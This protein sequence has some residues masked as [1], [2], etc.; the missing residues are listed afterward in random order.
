MKIGAII[1]CRYNSSRLPGKILK[2][3]NDKPILKYIVERLECSLPK[4]NIII[5][6]SN[7]TSDDPIYK[8]CEAEGYHCFRGSLENVAKRFM[9]CATDFN[10][11]YA[12]RING[13]NVFTD[14]PTLD[15]LLKITANDKYKFITNVAERTFPKGM[16]IEIIDTKYYRKKYPLF[17]NTSHKEHVTLFFYEHNES[18]VFYFYKN[19]EVPNAAGIQL[20][21]D[22]QKDY[23]LVSKI[24]SN[25]TKD[26]R[27]YNLKEIYSIYEKITANEF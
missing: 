23:Q 14:I 8:F 27:L 17:N 19:I 7:E 13:D 24:I 21:I 6:T 9:D 3:I 11:D 2:K 22:T 10:L 4:G 5:A 15:T 18:D 26:H 1:L 20:A 25:F 12:I 16:S